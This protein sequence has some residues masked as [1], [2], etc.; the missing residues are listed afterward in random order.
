MP[1]ET[2][3]G[4]ECY[5]YIIHYIVTIRYYVFYIY[6]HFKKGTMCNKIHLDDLNTMAVF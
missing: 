2:R 1:H 3:A 6:K 5:K 4:I